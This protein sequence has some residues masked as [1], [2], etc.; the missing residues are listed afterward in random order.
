MA[1]TGV[2]KWPVFPYH[3]LCSPDRMLN[4]QAF[5]I[6]LIYGDRDW[7]GTEG[8]DMVIKTSKFFSTGESQLIRVPDSGH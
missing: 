3:S 1:Y 7:M 5:P 8:P 4:W 6:C 2:Y